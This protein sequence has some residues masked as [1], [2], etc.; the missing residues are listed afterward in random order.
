LGAHVHDDATLKPAGQVY[1]NL[2]NLLRSIHLVDFDKS[3]RRVKTDRGE[4]RVGL[5][6]LD[7]ANAYS[8]YHVSDTHCFAAMALATASWGG[9]QLVSG[10]PS[11]YVYIFSEDGSDLATA[12]RIF[13]KSEVP[14]K[15]TIYGR[16]ARPQSVALVDV[17][18]LGKKALEVLSWSPAGSGIEVTVV[19]TLQAYWVQVDW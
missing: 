9:K 17:S 15:L 14:G 12:K 8:L 1:S 10:S 4:V 7:G 19:P 13:A 6:G 18:P 16:S 5:K 3:S 2:A 11:G